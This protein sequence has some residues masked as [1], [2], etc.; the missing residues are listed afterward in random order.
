[1]IPASVSGG[2]NDSGSK[3]QSSGN[4]SAEPSDE[5]TEDACGVSLDEQAIPYSNVP[6]GYW[7]LLNLIMA[8]LSVIIGMIN[9][10]RWLRR[11]KEDE[12][13]ES[14]AD[15]ED[16]SSKKTLLLSVKTTRAR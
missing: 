16:S 10:L 9:G 4:G 6:S 14:S 8:V 7:A 1:M 2:G 13:E 11:R 3:D 12:E 5:G 15:N